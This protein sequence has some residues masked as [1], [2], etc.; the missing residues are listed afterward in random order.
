MAILDLNKES[1]SHFQLVYYSDRGVKYCHHE[2]VKLLQDNHIKIS[3]T[4]NR[5]PLENAIAE[6][7]NGIILEE[8]FIHNK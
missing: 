8:H 5:D 3:M 4:E 6:K 2:Y 1:E 7:V